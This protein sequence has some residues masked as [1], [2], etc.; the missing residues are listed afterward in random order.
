MNELGEDNEFWKNGEYNKFIA[1]WALINHQL[2]KREEPKI[3]ISD[4]E[5]VGFNTTQ[6]MSPQNKQDKPKKLKSPYQVPDKN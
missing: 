1:D 5:T 4:D 3:L 6:M 2:S